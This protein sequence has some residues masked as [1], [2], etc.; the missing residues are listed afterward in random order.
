VA[1]EGRDDGGDGRIAASPIDPTSGQEPHARA[2]TSRQTSKA[3]QLNLVNP[4]VASRW[5]GGR[6]GQAR[7]DEAVRAGTH[8]QHRGINSSGPGR[9]ESDL[10]V[11]TK[12]HFAFRVDVWDDAGVSIIEHVAGIDDYQVALATFLAACQRW[13]GTPVTLRQGARVIEDSRRLRVV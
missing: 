2:I 12:T 9:V 3:I 4:A 13:P 11:K 8:T 6:A 1:G 7:L 5:L 10:S